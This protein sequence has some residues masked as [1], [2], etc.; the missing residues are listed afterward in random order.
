M[1]YNMK[2]KLRPHHVGISVGDLKE[3]IAWYQQHLGFELESEYDLPEIKT[4]I[5][6]VERGDFRIELFEHY[7]T[8]ILA[9]H[10]KHPLTDMQQQ[11]TLHICFQMEN[12][13]ED[14]FARF[15][16]EGVDVVMGPMPSPPND[17]IMGFIRDN[18]GNL[19]E[20]IQPKT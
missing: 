7:E 2:E 20:I 18:T 10:R 5:A 15:K 12:G 9:D 3:S 19:I 6:F 8:N 13:L 16:E 4:K 17:A 1:G 11:G 14:L